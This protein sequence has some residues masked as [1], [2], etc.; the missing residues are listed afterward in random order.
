MLEGTVDGAADG[1]GLGTVDGCAERSKSFKGAKVARNCT[2][3]FV[4]SAG[5]SMN[6]PKVPKVIAG[7]ETVGIANEY[8]SVDGESGGSLKNLRRKSSPFTKFLS[9]S[10]TSIALIP[11]ARRRRREKHHNAML[12]ECPDM[13]EQRKRR[14]V[15]A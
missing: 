1:V 4:S 13:V 7:G 11:L 2:P 14:E 9:L 8:V 10:S 12:C 5:C 6:A 15:G 3:S